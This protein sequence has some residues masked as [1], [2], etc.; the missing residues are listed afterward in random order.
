MGLTGE[1]M[2][3]GKGTYKGKPS[4][5]PSQQLMKT[6]DGYGAMMIWPEAGHF[7]RALKAFLPE[8]VGDERFSSFEAKRANF[9]TFRELLV[10]KI[11]MFTNKEFENFLATSDLPGSCVLDLAEI[12]DNEQ[13]I[14]NGIIVEHEVGRL[15]K[16][17]ETR[18]APLMSSTPLRIGGVCPM[19]GEHTALV[20]KR[21]GY[22]GSDID[23]LTKAGVFGDM[24]V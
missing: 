6:K 12:K 4:R 1:Q 20:L 3:G 16:I 13:V 8:L 10:P 15:G 22:N 23:A 11:A 7:D 14:H 5:R 9:S 19:R 17:R 21:H 18:P 24:E 2:V